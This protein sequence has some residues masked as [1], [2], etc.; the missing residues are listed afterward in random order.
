V[1]PFANPLGLWA[2]AL[3]PLLLAAALFLR[4]L[5]RRAA[6]RWGGPRNLRRLVVAPPREW[7]TITI[8]ALWV[9][10][11]LALLSFARPQWGEITENVQRVGLDVVVCLDTSRSMGVTDVNP[12]R[13]ERARLEIRSLL[14]S[15]EGDRVA[16]VAFSGVPVALSPLTE[17]MGAVSLLLDISDQDLIPP[18]GTDIGKGITESL[19]LLPQPHDRDQVILVFSDG[20]DQARESVVAARVAARLGIKIFCVGVGT[21]KGGPVPGPGGKPMTDSQTGMTALSRLE[22]Q[23]LRQVAGIADGRYWT[24]EGGEGVTP[25]ILEEF[26]RLK[27]REYATR[28]QAMRQDQFAW[29]LA[30]AL[31]LVL[32]CL[33]IPGRKR[34]RE[35]EPASPVRVAGSA[36]VLAALALLTSLALPSFAA[37]PASLARQAHAAYTAGQAEKALG[38][39]RRALQEGPPLRDAHVLRYNLGTCLLALKRPSEARDELTLALMGE[40]EEVKFRALYNLAHAYYDEGSSD[41]AL[42]SLKMLLLSEP[43]NRDAKLFYEWIL[44]NKPE[45]PPKKAP[46]QNEPPPPQA[47]PPDLLEQLPMPPPKDLQDQIKPRDNPLPSMKPW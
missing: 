19:K 3:L 47:Q 8:A 27:R 24:L 44:R 36:S 21:T 30:P 14:G 6:S 5:A 9:A 7:D 33:L 2:L 43:G 46:D 15:L 11:A 38:L 28:S 17:D 20:E 31:L 34:I 42:A 10:L 29:F 4:I 32:M 13:L 18:Q 12:S 41:K 40:R 37:S 35:T 23:A 45:Q 1:I 26:G 22:Q 16:L 25:E 39:Y